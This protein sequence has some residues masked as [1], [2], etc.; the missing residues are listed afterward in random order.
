MQ[1]GHI[2]LICTEHILPTKE[3]AVST[4]WDMASVAI[5]ENVVLSM[6]NC[7]PWVL[8]HVFLPAHLFLPRLLI[9][10]RLRNEVP[11]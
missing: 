9:S 6:V 2:D 7:A 4:A 10:L 1:P 5:E 8:L 3:A 11:H